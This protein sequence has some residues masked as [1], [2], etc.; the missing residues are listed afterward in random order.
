MCCTRLL[1]SRKFT[2]T[3]QDEVLKKSRPRSGHFRAQWRPEEDLNMSLLTALT[4]VGK[5]LEEAMADMSYPGLRT[6][7]LIDISSLDNASGSPAA[8]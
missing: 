3:L 2:P 8:Q 4:I 5:T 6:V 1:V 7:H